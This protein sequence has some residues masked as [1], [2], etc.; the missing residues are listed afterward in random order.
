MLLLFQ[1]TKNHLIYVWWKKW[2]EVII[3]ILSDFLFKGGYMKTIYYYKKDK[4]TLYSFLYLEKYKRY[5][6]STFPPNHPH[7]NIHLKKKN[8]KIRQASKNSNSKNN[9]Q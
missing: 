7:Y 4:K 8:D 1:P 2:V 6:A 9:S 3:H 5:L